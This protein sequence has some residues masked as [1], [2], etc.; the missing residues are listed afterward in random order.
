MVRSAVLESDEKLRVLSMLVMAGDSAEEPIL[1]FAGHELVVPVHFRTSS[2]SDDYIRGHRCCNCCR[3][4]LSCIAR[5]LYLELLPA[6]SWRV[7]TVPLRRAILLRT[8][9]PPMT[10]LQADYI[11]ATVFGRK[12]LPATW[13]CLSTID[14]YAT[15]RLCRNVHVMSSLERDFS[16][17]PL[18][19][20]EI[21]PDRGY[22]AVPLRTPIWLRA[23]VLTMY[24]LQ[25]HNSIHVC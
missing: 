19:N 17:M 6:A 7:I 15:V 9:V 2:L 16:A 3:F 8:Q 18:L 24:T 10:G 22:V 5:V 23:E 4:S 11:V 14:L 20:M 12:L 13:W 21:F 1:M 25:R